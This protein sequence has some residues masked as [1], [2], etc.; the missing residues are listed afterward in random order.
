MNPIISV[1]D[2]STNKNVKKVMCTLKLCLRMNEAT[3]GGTSFGNE[4]VSCV[5]R[6]RD[7]K[8]ISERVLR[9]SLYREMIILTCLSVCLSVIS[10]IVF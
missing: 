8:Y 6:C 3:N 10:Y 1:N 5:L 2:N 7:N 4:L 9:S